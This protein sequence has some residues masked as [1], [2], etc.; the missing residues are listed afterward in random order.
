MKCIFSV[1]SG[2]LFFFFIVINLFDNYVDYLEKLV[3][4]VVIVKNKFYGIYWG[5]VDVFFGKKLIKK[6]LIWFKI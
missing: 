1:R 2:Y 5:C 3:K 4:V 6:V